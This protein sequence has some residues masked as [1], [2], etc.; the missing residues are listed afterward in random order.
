[1]KALILHDTVAADAAPDTQ[2]VLVQARHVR[3]ALEE[4]GYTVEIIPVTLDMETLRRRLVTAGPEIVFNLVESIANQGC[5][6]A[7]VPA[8]LDSLDLAYTGASAET[9]FLTSSKL[10]TKQLLQAQGLPTPAWETR[11]SLTGGKAFEPGE[12]IIK[13][14]WEDASIGLDE[15]SVVAVE[16]ARELAHAWTKIPGI[17]S[18]ECF[19]ERYIS[20]REFA[21][22]L[23]ADGD[24][25]WTLPPA[26][27]VFNDYAPGKHRILGYRAKWDEES[28][29]Y[30]HT[31][32]RFDLPAEDHALAL[33]LTALADRS[34]SAGGG[35]GYGRV[36]FRVDEAGHP[37]ILEINANPCLAPDAGFT[38]AAERAGLTFTGTID[39]IVRDALRRKN[40]R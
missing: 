10:L 37:W 5:F 21:V 12:Y 16:T 23:I 35:R 39:L 6:S 36:D 34:W 31:N 11:I 38:A 3:Q 40:H 13:P 27:M 18:L 26:E 33:T 7:W 9:L 14:V 22:A 8:L 29:E 20:G 15:D 2:D 32:R 4:L 30:R 24:R 19:A 17:D 1:M 28:F 25:A